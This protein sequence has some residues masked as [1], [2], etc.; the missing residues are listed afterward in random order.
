MFCMF[1]FVIQTFWLF[2]DELA[3][4]GLDILIDAFLILKESGNYPDLRL[5]IAG[6]MTEEDESFVQQQKNKLTSCTRAGATGRNNDG[7]GW[8][9]V[10]QEEEERGCTPAPT[11]R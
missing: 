11:W 1:I 3:G 5:E 8:A 9:R 6:G 7:T 10:A 4:K 2:I